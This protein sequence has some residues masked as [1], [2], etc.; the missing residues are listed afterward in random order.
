MFQILGPATEIIFGLKRWRT[1]RKISNKD[2]IFISCGFVP[3]GDEK[4]VIVVNTFE[5]E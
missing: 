2:K 4:Q 1:R 5:K 3:V